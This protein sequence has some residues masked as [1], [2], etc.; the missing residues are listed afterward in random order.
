MDHLAIRDTAPKR[1]VLVLMPFDRAFDDVYAFGIKNVCEKL[2]FHCER[3]DE[4]IFEGSILDRIYNQISK[5][6]LII[7]D[8]TGQN[9]N[10]FY[11]A[12]YAHATGEERNSSYKNK[13]RHSVRFDAVRALNLRRRDC[14]IK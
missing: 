9:P 10:F 5:A 3:V 4:Q 13:G 12:G 7:A 2:Q 1:F 6:D 8:L 14:G 11:E